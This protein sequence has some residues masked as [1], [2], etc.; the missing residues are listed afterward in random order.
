MTAP[1]VAVTANSLAKPLETLRATLA[2]SAEFR[3]QVAAASE[4]AAKNHIYYDEGQD[5]GTEARPRAI[6]RST[7]DE[8]WEKRG[9]GAYHFGE[10][11]YSIFLEFP[12]DTDY[13]TRALRQDAFLTFSNAVGQIIQELLSAAEDDAA[14][15]MTIAAL[16]IGAMGE[17]DPK[18]N[19]GARFWGAELL[20]T[21]EHTTA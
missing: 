2:H 10:G 9:D 14:T 4:A 8:I 5:D 18:R 6:V 12:T 20:V 17:A 16:E 19:G 21:P 1:T 15:Y 3:T 7:K 13:L 11:T